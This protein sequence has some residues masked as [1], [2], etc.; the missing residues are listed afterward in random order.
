MGVSDRDLGAH[1]AQPGWS[2]VE[3]EG[4]LATLDHVRVLEVH[5]GDA[6]S[7]GQKV[8]SLLLVRE[9]HAVGG[10]LLA[11]ER[12]LPP[13]KAVHNM[14]LDWRLDAANLTAKHTT[15]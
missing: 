14:L 12:V 3:R 15:H 4:S 13:V 5:Q 11:Q 8:L 6:A 2:F 10:R 1:P 7:I 9:A